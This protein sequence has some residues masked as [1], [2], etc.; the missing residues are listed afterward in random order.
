MYFWLYSILQDAMPVMDVV[1]ISDGKV[2]VTVI[3]SNGKATTDTV[4]LVFRIFT[5]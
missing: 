4:S 2:A 5:V 1:V 3:D